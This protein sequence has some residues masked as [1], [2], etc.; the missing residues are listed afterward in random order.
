M[1]ELDRFN[2]KIDDVG[3]NDLVNLTRLRDVVKK[4]MGEDVEIGDIGIEDII[5]ISETNTKIVV[6]FNNIS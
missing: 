3:E 6:Y 1:V 2:I 4:N 5:G